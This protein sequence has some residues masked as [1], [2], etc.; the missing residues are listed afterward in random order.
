MSSFIGRVAELADLERLVGG[1]RLVTVTGPGGSGKTRT[2]LRLLDRLGPAAVDRIAF[3]DLAALRDPALIPSAI[4]VALLL[5]DEPGRD[6][7]D[8]IADRI[9]DDHVLLV[10]DNLEQLLPAGGEVA[11]SL[12]QRCPNLR[13]V[14][15]SRMPLDVRGEREYP[16][17]P[18]PVPGPAPEPIEELERN[19]AV[20]LFIDRARAVNPR[21]SLTSANASAV[22]AIC[23]R[24][25][26][27]PLALELAAARTRVLS[28]Q[29][30][31]RLLDRA[32][33]V[34][35]SGPMDA[36]LRHRSLRATVR[37]S[38]D[39]LPPEERRV[40]TRLSVFLGGARLDTAGH[41]FGGDDVD[42]LALLGVLDQLV[43]K[44]LVR[45]VVDPD[46]EPRFTMLETIRELAAE[47]L[48]SDGDEPTADRL[49]A[50]AFLALAERA[51]L[52]GMPADTHEWYLRFDRE[53]DNLRS[54]TAWLFDARADDAVRMV[55]LLYRF[56]MSR[57]HADEVRDWIERALERSRGRASIA[58]AGAF[59][60][61]AAL[62]YVDGR[63]ADAL[64]LAEQGYELAERVGDRLGGTVGLLWLARIS[65][66]AGEGA[67]ARAAYSEV[68]R[69]ADEL[70]RPAIKVA[71]MAN[72]G[73]LELHDRRFEEAAVV[74]RG[75]LDI[76]R[77]LGT[78]DLMAL[79]A[80]GFSTALVGKHDYA[81]ALEAVRDCV[82]TI[83]EFTALEGRAGYLLHVLAAIAAATGSARVGARLLPIGD[84]LLEELGNWPEPYG[85]DLRASTERTLRAQLG[86]AFEAAFESGRS[87]SVEDAFAEGLAL[88]VRGARPGRG[89]QGA[90]PTGRSRHD[91]TPRELEILALVAAG[92]S[93][94]EIAEALFISKKT[95]S[96]HVAN[97][98][99]KLAVANR[100]EIALAARRLGLADPEIG[101][102]PPG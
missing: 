31:L 57:L 46:G 6:L 13:I 72:L 14:A 38:Y 75:S 81:G 100:V 25:D 9:G 99:G 22:A 102:P 84:R 77:S 47:Q 55:G 67:R 91:L 61:G 43:R 65:T 49:H 37:W 96:V 11:R 58:A 78:L 66:A 27:L 90:A 29:A 18:L 36:P 94:G 89:P 97:I 88:E 85:G 8:R 32:L 79:S 1:G 26:G 83:R 98:K 53:R 48:E 7:L 24:L 62:A 20:T 82:A 44:A 64:P 86:S 17:E 28:P 19:D 4:A 74:L 92:R 15:T 41:V 10:L 34:L 68:I 3:V 40:F 33:P 50:E 54:A 60:A 101:P 80:E 30:L 12:L 93:D 59:R 16:L 87:L 63:L 5:K 56:W 23:R 95:A 71:A 42:G 73:V 21:F 52:D 39:L 51:S 35:T 45:T 69:R 70:D 2:V 76:A